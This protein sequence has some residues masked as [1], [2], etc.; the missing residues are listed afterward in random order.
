MHI[1]FFFWKKLKPPV[2]AFVSGYVLC[3]QFWILDTFNL[4]LSSCSSVQV[5]LL[6][7]SEETHFASELCLNL[8]SKPVYWMMFKGM[9]H[10]TA[11]ATS[12]VLTSRSWSWL[13]PLSKKQWGRR[14]NLSQQFLYLPYYTNTTYRNYILNEWFLQN[15]LLSNHISSLSSPY[16]LFFYL[17]FLIDIV[18]CMRNS[19]FIFFLFH[20]INSHATSSFSYMP[21]YLMLRKPAKLDDWDCTRTNPGRIFT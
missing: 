7:C 16:P 2:T 20:F 15:K 12:Y 8:N 17:D 9:K 21:T 4:M 6:F 1:R 10:K 5:A 3:F 18:P 11:G 14:G 19:F 13:L